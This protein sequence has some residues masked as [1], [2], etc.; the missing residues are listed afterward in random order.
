MNLELR[1]SWLLRWGVLFAGALLFVGWMTFLDF[2]QNPLAEFQDYK[3]ESLQ[4]SVGSALDRGDWGLFIAY[5]GLALLISLP[6]IR[7]LMTALLFLKQKEKI[8]ATVAFL[9]FATLILSFSLGI[10]L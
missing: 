7:V 10:E 3:N 2:S 8:L 1:I 9:V 6:L 4:Q 5:L